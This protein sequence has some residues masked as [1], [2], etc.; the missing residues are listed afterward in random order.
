MIAKD[1]LHRAMFALLCMVFTAHVFH[2]WGW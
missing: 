1:K 2:L